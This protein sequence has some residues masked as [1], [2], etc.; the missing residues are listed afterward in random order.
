MGSPS[1]GDGLPD[2]QPQRLI[3]VSGFYIDVYEVTNE[4]YERFVDS[5][6]HPMPENSNP[7]ATLW[8]NLHPLAGT[9]RHPVVNVS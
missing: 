4:A 8:N 5:T 7:R 6:G 2:E 1:G 3:Y 9:E